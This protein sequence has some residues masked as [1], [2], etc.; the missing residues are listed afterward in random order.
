M[1]SNHLL[2]A[3]FIA[4][5]LLAPKVPLALAGLPLKTGISPAVFFLLVWALVSPE[6]V[7]RG[8]LP[9]RNSAVAGLLGFAVYA[10]CISAVSMEWV[11]VLYAGQYL[12]Y[13][14][15][16]TVLLQAYLNEAMNRGELRRSFQI[17]AF[18]GTVFAIGV[19]VSVWTGPFFPHQTQWTERDW[20]GLT[21]QRGAG[22]A[23]GVNTA[24]ASLLTMTPF[25][26]YV[27]SRESRW[28]FLLAVTG[29]LA[30][31]ATLSRGAVIALIF[32]IG[33]VIIIGLMRT[34]LT[35]AV[36]VSS[37]RRLIFRGMTALAFGVIVFA[38][39]S[40]GGFE[41][42]ASAVQLGVGLGD[43]TIV[44]DDFD[45][46]AQIWEESLRQ[47]MSGN[48]F[49]LLFGNGFRMTGNLDEYS[50]AWFT[51]HNLYLAFLGDFG[52]IGSG[53]FMIAFLLALLKA[54]RDVLF[55]SERKPATKAT[56]VVLIAL[57]IH[58][59]TE[60]FLY[61]PILLTL[62]IAYL[63]LAELE[64]ERTDT[65]RLVLW[66]RTRASDE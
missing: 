47:W 50:E 20:N 51:P 5:L 37:A 57:A 55:F 36:S 27:Y 23:D 45:L 31:F 65:I 8:R 13:A 21:L 7:V 4:C 22:F 40:Q 6:Y 11:S 25:L 29:I 17:M 28:G 2:F 42:A 56:F 62:V 35:L 44:S 43:T 63:L 66:P 18:L 1:T 39:V 54:S 3:A 59:V 41:D 61:S 38:V 46:R 33:I 64:A 52:L 15:L 19:I 48:T 12:I 58:N 14:I 49:E 9:L 32:S 34:A 60:A 24:A 30:I 53:L 26:L 16:G 10:F